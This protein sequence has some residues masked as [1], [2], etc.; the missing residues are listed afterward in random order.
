MVN[1]E[2]GQGDLGILNA[3][4][5]LLKQRFNADPDA[6]RLVSQYVKGRASAADS[7]LLWEEIGA[8]FEALYPDLDESGRNSFKLKAVSSR[9]LVDGLEQAAGR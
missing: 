4:E 3:R 7:H 9:Y 8:A 5:D 2:T 6:R 1:Q